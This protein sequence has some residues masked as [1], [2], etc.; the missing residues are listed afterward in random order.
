MLESPYVIARLSLGTANLYDCWF[1]QGLFQLSHGRIFRYQTGQGTDPVQSFT[2]D[3]IN[4]LR[5]CEMDEDSTRIQQ[6]RDEATVTPT[7]KAK[8]KAQCNQRGGD[9]H[10][11]GTVL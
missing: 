5:K 1:V 3:N 11:I 9:R 2:V 4:R 6:G 7:G 8:R 10:V